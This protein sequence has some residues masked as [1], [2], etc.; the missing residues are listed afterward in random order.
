MPGSVSGGAKAKS[1]DCSSNASLE[2]AV[3]TRIPKK[4]T[5]GSASA[6]S[7][8]KPA[9]AKRFMV[10]V[11]V[12]I[13]FAASILALSS[14]AVFTTRELHEDLQEQ[15]RRN[16]DSFPF[17]FND[18][19]VEGWAVLFRAGGPW[20]EKLENATWKGQ[21]LPATSG[22][23]SFFLHVGAFVDV[24]DGGGQHLVI[25]MTDDTRDWRAAVLERVRAAHPSLVP[26]VASM[27]C[28]LNGKEMGAVCRPEDLE[29][30]ALRWRSPG[31]LRG[32][33]K[34]P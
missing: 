1:A 26:F 33:P 27:R 29:D 10:M 24:I 4:V 3:D 11:V 20:H 25:P 34:V 28:M 32:A 31:F 15:A 16:C 19:G 12:A 9:R 23:R 7:K 2:E 8:A 18:S 13:A 14:L 6:V 21:A 5:P 22:R 30:A 17:G